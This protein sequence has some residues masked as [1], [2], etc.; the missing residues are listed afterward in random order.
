MIGGLPKKSVLLTNFS[1]LKHS[2]GAAPGIGELGWKA[3]ETLEKLIAQAVSKP[4]SMGLGSGF[5][6]KMNLALFV[7][8]RSS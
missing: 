2:P 8:H 1:L 7:A 4:F 3:E 5:F 6:W